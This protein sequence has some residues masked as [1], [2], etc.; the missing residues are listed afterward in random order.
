MGHSVQCI[1]L[2]SMVICSGLAIRANSYNTESGLWYGI[3]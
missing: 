2:H 1:E 3:F